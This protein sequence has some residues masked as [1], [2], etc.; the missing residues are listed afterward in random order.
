[1]ILQLTDGVTTCNL[2]WDSVV[3]RKYIQTRD[4]WAPKVP[5]RQ[6]SLLGGRGSF[7]IVEETIPLVVCGDSAVE[8]LANLARLAGLLD[9]A[10]RWWNGE[11]GIAPVLFQYT[12]NG[13]ATLCQATVLGPAE[14]NQTSGVELPVSFNSSTG[15][16]VTGEITLRF[17]HTSPWL[18]AVTQSATSGSSAMPA[19]LTATLASVQSIASPT[20]LTLAGAL[21]RTSSQLRSGMLIVAPADHIELFEAESMTGGGTSTAD[22]TAH[23]SGGN[24]LRF[25]TVSTQFTI[26]KTFSAPF[27]ALAY[28]MEVFV[29]IRIN[30]GSATSTC[31]IRAMGSREGNSVIGPTR[32]VERGSAAAPQIVSLGTVASR[33]PFT[34]LQ[35]VLFF[36]DATVTSVDLD[37]VACVATNGMEDVTMIG[38]DGDSAATAFPTGATTDAVSLVIDHGAL[39]ETG[40]FVEAAN[41][42]AS[43]KEPWSWNGDAFIVTKAAAIGVLALFAAGTFWRPWDTTAVAAVVFTLTAVRTPGLVTPT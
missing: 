43:T 32:V 39:I 26:V 25:S 6:Q 27:A 7:E 37:Y 24:V 13:G 3:N 1:M 28:E 10:Q 38:F 21:Q 2:V 15:A 8:A 4:T 14:G 33:L 36:T 16:Y 20:K 41:T 12:P 19:V 42:T 18:G 9:K 22:A 23:A 35:I 29:A 31:T 5:P 11:F 30:G 40:P 34:F 17:L